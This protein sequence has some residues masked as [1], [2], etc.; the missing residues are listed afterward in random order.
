[1]VHVYCR[2]FV[3][4]CWCV[5]SG[6]ACVGGLGFIKVI[7]IV[8]D[9]M[10]DFVVFCVFWFDCLFVYLL[11]A[12]SLVLGLFYLTCLRRLFC[13]LMLFDVGVKFGDLVVVVFDMLVVRVG[14]WD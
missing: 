13:C 6:F 11:V 12:C 2:L 1:M 9:L 5:N 4:F 3:L 10:L 7:R 8:V 14:W